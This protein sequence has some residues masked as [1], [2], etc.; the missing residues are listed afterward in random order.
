MHG[1]VENRI[2]YF[3]WKTLRKD[4]SEDLGIDG[5]IILGWVLG[6]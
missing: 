3:G 6:R 1:R 5:S 2:Q 4:N